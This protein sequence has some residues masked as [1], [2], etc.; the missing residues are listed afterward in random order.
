MVAATAM[1]ISAVS[2]LTAAPA[3]FYRVAQRTA[4]A[5][6]YGRYM[7]FEARDRPV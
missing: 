5:E 6:G 4:L 3:F 1:A 7:A 2:Q